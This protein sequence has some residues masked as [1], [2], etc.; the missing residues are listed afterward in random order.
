MY[1]YYKNGGTVET[2]GHQGIKNLFSTKISLTTDRVF[3]YYAT[4]F[5]IL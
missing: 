1:T 4:S 3:I 5:V 2:V